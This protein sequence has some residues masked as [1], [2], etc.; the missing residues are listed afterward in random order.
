MLRKKD[1]MLDETD[2]IILDIIENNETLGT[3]K[4][5]E[6]VNLAPKNLI[7]RIT[8]LEQNKFINKKSIPAKP[9]G[10]QRIFK[11]TALGSTAMSAYDQ[12]QDIKDKLSTEVGNAT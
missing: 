8:K 12:L 4:L 2:Y 10:R 3:L 1:F 9:K 11:V 5:S 6:K 7:A